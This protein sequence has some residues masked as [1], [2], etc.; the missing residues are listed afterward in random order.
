[1]KISVCLSENFFSKLQCLQGA[2]QPNRKYKKKADREVYSVLLFSGDA[3][4]QGLTA[5]SVTA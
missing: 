4:S 5:A 1:M 2:S 3:E